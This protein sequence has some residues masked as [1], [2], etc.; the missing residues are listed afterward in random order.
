MIFLWAQG[1]SFFCFW[2]L[3]MLLFKSGK[4]ELSDKLATRY[5]QFA[6]KMTDRQNN[7]KMNH[8]K[9]RENGMIQPMIADHK[10]NRLKGY[11]QS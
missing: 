3:F 11:F 9:M 5:Y 10:H 6:G 7:K 4:S 1:S 2:L 8:S